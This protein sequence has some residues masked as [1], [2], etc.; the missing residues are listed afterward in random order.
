M[1]HPQLSGVSLL[2]RIGQLGPTLPPSMRRVA[3]TILAHQDSASTLTISELARQCNT[4]ETSVV[5]FC[6]ALGVGGYSEL[7]LALAADAGRESASQPEGQS[8]GD[9]ISPE[10]SLPEIIAKISWTERRAIDETLSSMNLESLAKVIDAI[11]GADRLVCY[12]IGASYL[13]ALDL[14]QKLRRI[15]RRVLSFSDAHEA[16]TVVSLFTPR[17]VL[18]V[19]SHSGETSE[20]RRL[21]EVA[22]G[23]GATT[24]AIT[25]A[26]GSTIDKRADISLYTAVRESAYRSGAMASRVSQLAL[27]DGIFV[28]LAQRHHDDVAGALAATRAGTDKLREG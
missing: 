20:P 7:R 22:H 1:A 3:E 23:C 5:R 27:V 16:M 10:D 8:W 28:G 4:S 25:N 6:H 19:V 13:G 17:D 11:D 18:L 15:G 21:M 26:A 12:G 9:D 2:T 14:T 24:I